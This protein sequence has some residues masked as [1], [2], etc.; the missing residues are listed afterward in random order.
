MINTP[1]YFWR[2][3]KDVDSKKKRER[4]QPETIIELTN[5]KI[6]KR[7]LPYVTEV[8]E[9]K[10]KVKEEDNIFEDETK[11]EEDKTPEVE[12]G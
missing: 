7:V 3:E 8:I 12:N 2:N 9:D 1:I 5:K 11:K 4:L 6:V 10:D